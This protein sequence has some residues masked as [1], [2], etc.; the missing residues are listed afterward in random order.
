MTS[1]G[2]ADFDNLHY[3]LFKAESFILS[4]SSENRYI[5]SIDDYHAYKCLVHYKDGTILWH[6]KKLSNLGSR[7]QCKFTKALIAYTFHQ[8]PIPI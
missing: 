7:E 4:G 2:S 1:R 3:D 8:W 6:L 5:Q